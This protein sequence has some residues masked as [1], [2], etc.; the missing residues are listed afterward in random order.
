MKLLKK[1]LSLGLAST[2]LYSYT[3]TGFAQNNKQVEYEDINLP[4]VSA[5]LVNNSTG[6]ITKLDMKKVSYPKMRINKNNDKNTFEV[7]YEAT[8]K[9]PVPPKSRATVTDTTTSD[10]TA[11]LTIEYYLN[12]NTEK[13]QMKKVKGYW[14]GSSSFMYFSDREVAFGDGDVYN[15]HSSHYYP[16]KNSFS[17]T[18]GW[19]VVLYYPGTDYSGP[20]AFSSAT[21]SVS[22]MESSSHTIECFINNFN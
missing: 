22:G 6:E 9:I 8:A 4:E 21:V 3:L 11:S 7:T 17:Y 20:R 16:S 18:T 12:K 2:I 1:L 10:A 14:E 19:P 15:G 5:R 13:F